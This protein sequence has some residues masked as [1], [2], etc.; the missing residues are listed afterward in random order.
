MLQSSRQIHRAQHGTVMILSVFY[1]TI[2]QQ[3]LANIS[4]VISQV[5]II[6]LLLCAEKNHILQTEMMSATLLAAGI[7]SLLQVTC[8]IRQVMTSYLWDKVCC[9]K[10]PVG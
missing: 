2:F 9:Y 3:V 1:I 6:C 8:G 10:L 4:G 5:Y 7:T